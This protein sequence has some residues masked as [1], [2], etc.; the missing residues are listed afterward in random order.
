MRT[1]RARTRARARRVRGARVRVRGA[2]GRA[3]EARLRAC[4][5]GARA[6]SPGD[7]VRARVCAGRTR[8]RAGVR[9]ERRADT[10]TRAHFRITSRIRQPLCFLFSSSLQSG[11]AWYLLFL[12]AFAV[13]PGWIPG[14]P[15]SQP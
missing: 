3:G 8:G 11:V 9:A 10:R 12:F 2:R 6:C 15:W 1:C 5:R 4:A 7:Q 13:N 14:F